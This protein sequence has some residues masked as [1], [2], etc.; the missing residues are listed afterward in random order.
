M[1]KRTG[2]LAGIGVLDLSR[3]LP[4]PYCSLM[5]ADMGAEVIKIEQPGMGDYA[6]AMPPVSGPYGSI[7]ASVNRN[8]RSLALD[9]KNPQGR[10]VLLR[11]IEGA[12][13]LIEGFRPGVMKKLGLSYQELTRVNAQLVYC[14]ISGYGQNG[15]YQAR[16]GHDLNFCGLGG[17][18][19]LTGQE[20]TGPAMPGFQLADLS[21]GMFALSAILAALFGRGQGQG[22]R[23]IDIS[24]AEGAAAFM[25]PYTSLWLDQGS[26]PQPGRDALNGGIPAYNVYRTADGKYMT[27]AA[28]EPKFWSGFCAA[29]ERPELAELSHSLGE[30]GLRVREQLALIFAEKTRAEWIRF[31]ADRD[32]CCEAVYGADE[33]DINPIFQES[34]L[35]FPLT[36]PVAGK[37][38][39]QHTP[40]SRPAD[41][42]TF[43]AP[44]LL[45]EHSREILTEAGYNEETIAQMMA[46]KIAV[47]A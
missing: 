4:G 11:L 21:S 1:S 40:L 29:I 22:G 46:E 5:L 2:P 20:E 33:V 27:L 32:V 36:H 25:L 45:G 44:P 43:T 9:L 38:S 15:S 31:F 41:P 19:S 16:A 10:D 24:M 23:Y 13:V 14:S 7:F 28:L 47:Q 17:P 37:L 26:K 35:V 6:R 18:L 8:K 39:Q 30:E 42:N 12:D 3:L 34:G